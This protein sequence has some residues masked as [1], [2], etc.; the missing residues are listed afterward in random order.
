VVG[1]HDA[2]ANSLTFGA[3]CRGRGFDLVQLVDG[4]GRRLLL[5]ERRQVRGRIALRVDRGRPVLDDLV[6]GEAVEYAL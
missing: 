6:F 5:A 4:G 2:T 3:W 1:E